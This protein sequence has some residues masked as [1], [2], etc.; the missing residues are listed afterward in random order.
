[1]RIPP[2]TKLSRKYNPKSAGEICFRS[3][4]CMNADAE[5]KNIR[6][7]DVAVE[8]LGWIP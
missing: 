2:P 4:V 3:S 6:K 1:V 5:T 8:D 7:D